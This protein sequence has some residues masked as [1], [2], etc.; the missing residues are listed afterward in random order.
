MEVPGGEVEERDEENE[1]KKGNFGGVSLEPTTC[2][3]QI[4]VDLNG[5]FHTLE[6][7][8]VEMHLAKI[9]PVKGLRITLHFI[10]EDEEMEGRGEYQFYPITSLYVSHGKGTS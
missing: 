9:Q 7:F 10:K 3:Y 4:T 8:E 2:D 6:T 1:R 5:Q